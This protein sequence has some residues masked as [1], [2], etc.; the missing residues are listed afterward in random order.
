[1]DNLQLMQNVQLKS[2]IMVRL[3]KFIFEMDRDLEVARQAYAERNV[4]LT[5]QAHQTNPSD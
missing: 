4:E 3:I 2:L 1:M 5:K